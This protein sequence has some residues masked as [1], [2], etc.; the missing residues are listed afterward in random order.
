MLDNR[1]KEDTIRMGTK[2]GGLWT[3]RKKYQAATRR[4][5]DVR[6]DSTKIGENIYKILKNNHTCLF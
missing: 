3:Y 2:T 6:E 5:K 4:C 1:G